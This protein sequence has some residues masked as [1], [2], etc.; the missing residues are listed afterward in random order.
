[1]RATPYDEPLGNW[2]L[3]RYVRGK[4]VGTGEQLAAPGNAYPIC[5]WTVSVNT[6]TPAGDGR[7]NAQ[8]TESMTFQLGPGIIFRP[9]KHEVWGR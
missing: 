8:F 6:A 2:P 1:L 7:T 3:A 4:L 5:V 9:T